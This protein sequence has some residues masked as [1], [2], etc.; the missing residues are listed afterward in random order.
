MHHIS[1]FKMPQ[2][3]N[4]STRPNRFVA[5]MWKSHRQKGGGGNT[6]DLVAI[7][8][9]SACFGPLTVWTTFTG[10]TASKVARVGPHPNQHTSTTRWLHQPFTSYSMHFQG[11]EKENEHEI[12]KFWAGTRA[13]WQRVDLLSLYDI[14]FFT[15]SRLFSSFSVSAQKYPCKK[16]PFRGIFI[17]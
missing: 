8:R 3:T 15:S 4:H 17:T 1:C 7:F 10:C 12:D 14:M 2:S 11:R 5:A 6:R 9:P 13:A 16:M